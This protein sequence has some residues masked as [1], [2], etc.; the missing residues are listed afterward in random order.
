MKNWRD[1][2]PLNALKAFAAFAEAGSVAQAGAATG[3]THAAISQQIRALEQHMGLALVSR[4]G[5]ELVLTAQGRMLADAALLA[6]GNVAELAAS[7]TGAD[8]NRALHITTTPSFAIGWLMP[9]LADFRSH[10]PGIDLVID[11]TPDLRQL[12][13]EGADIAFRYGNGSWPGTEARLLVSSSIVAVAAPSLIAPAAVGSVADLADLPWLQELGTSEATAFL[14]KYGVERGAR[15][16]LTS[17]PGNLMLEAA[18]A[19]QGVAVT[20]R[21][22]VEADIAAGRLHVVVE[23][24]EREG[25]FLVTPAGVLRPPAKAFAQ[26]A[27]R[28]VF[29]IA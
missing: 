6:F 29:P 17:L 15:F 9:R 19:G 25:Y 22:F 21:A 12:G 23:D 3:V 1:L 13:P 11:P 2:P 16:G 10:H 14:E 18:R 24:D 28:Q 7:L 8:A 5:R 27:R 20:A 26:W 4:A